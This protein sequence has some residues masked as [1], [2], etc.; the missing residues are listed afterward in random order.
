MKAKSNYKADIG[1]II[2]AVMII[3]VVGVVAV[4]GVI[5]WREISTEL[6]ATPEFQAENRSIVAIETVDSFASPLLDMFVVAIFLGFLLFLIISSAVIDANPMLVGGFIF[7]LLIAIFLSAQ[8]AE[9]FTEFI[10]TDEITG[11]IAELPMTNFILGRAYPSL[12]A[13][14]GFI[15]LMVLY[16]RSKRGVEV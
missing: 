8:F 16:G 1:S 5:A 3:F 2:I 10:G 6:R 4:V 7:A 9:A 14:T 13:V 15:V 12:I 11:A